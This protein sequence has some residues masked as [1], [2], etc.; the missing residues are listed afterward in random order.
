MSL[1]KH[2]RIL[3]GG[4]EAAQPADSVTVAFATTDRKHVDQHFGAA[5]AFAVYAVSPSHASLVEY[6]QFGELQYDGHED[7][8][9]PKLALLQGCAAVYCQAVG[10]SAIRQ[11]LAAGIQPLR[12]EEGSVIEQLIRD[13]QAD[14]RA[15][16]AAWAE[17][18]LLRRQEPT[19]DRFAAMEAE[20]WQE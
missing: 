11:L 15:G 4:V 13:L 7:K 2:L 12:V 17:K 6:A 1:R 18:A 5:M 14:W 19:D 3:A 10:G 20:G 16:N 8:L 9:S